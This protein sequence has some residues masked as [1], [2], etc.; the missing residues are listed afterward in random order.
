MIP[1]LIVPVLARYEL[2]DQ[3]LAS[4]DHPVDHLIVIDNGNEL[5]LTGSRWANQVTMLN[6]P[7]NL[8]VAGSWNLGIKCAPFAP[9]WLIVNFDVTFPPGSLSMF[10]NQSSRDVLLLS[11]GSPPWCAFTLGDKIVDKVGL[12]DERLHPAYFE[13][14]DME[15]RCEAAGFD[16]VHSDIPVTHRNSS[17]LDAG[18]HTLNSRTFSDNAEFYG[19]KVAVGDVSW[20]WSLTRRRELT[21]D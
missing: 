1:A 11:A 3:M 5:E 14:N 15:R 16:V 4:I 18:F 13:D 12:F 2:L 17:T 10:A 20:G 8:G 7:A 9:W 6:M 19:H 21:W